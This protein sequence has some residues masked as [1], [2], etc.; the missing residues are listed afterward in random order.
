MD[1]FQK[2]MHDSHTERRNVKVE[3]ILAIEAGD[4]LDL[5]KKSQT[6]P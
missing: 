2:R 3:R 1:I 4:L 6:I 5:V